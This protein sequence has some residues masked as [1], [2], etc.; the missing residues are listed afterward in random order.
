MNKTVLLPKLSVEGIKKN[1]ATY[2]PYILINSF[3]IFVFFI[4]SAISANEFLRNVP[5]AMYVY[6]LLQISLMLLGIILAPI[7]ITSNEF[8]VKQRKK[9]LGLY[10]I[11][12]MEKK[13]IAIIMIVEQCIIY[14]VSI[15]IGIIISV[16]FSKLS[17]MSLLK[18]ASLPSDIKFTVKPV[19]ITATLI[20]FG[21]IAAYNIFTNVY[22]VSRLN[23]I[24]LLGESKKGEK[25][26]RFLAFKA[27]LGVL[28]V[29]SGY[30]IAGIM[31]MDS[32]LFM[33]FFAAVALVVIGTYFLFSSVSIIVLKLLQRNK[34][35]YYKSS[36][37]TTVSG[38][39]YRMKKSART[40]AN[41]CVF[42]TM[43]IITLICT[44][45]LY[46][47]QEDGIRFNYPLDVRYD[48]HAD[49]FD[50]EA[51][52]KIITDTAFEKNV[53]VKEKT[54]FDYIKLRVHKIN[55]HVEFSDNYKELPYDEKAIIRL[56]TVD[57]FNEIENTDLTLGENEILVYSNEKDF[58]QREITLGSYTFTVKEEL[59]KILTESKEESTFANNVYY[60]IFA[61]D[62]YFPALLMESGF[63][64][65]ESKMYTIRF[66]LE[67]EDGNKRE[68]VN[69]LN[70]KAKALAGFD[71][72]KNIFEFGEE[73]RAM[74]GGLLFMGIFFGLI[75]TVCLVIMM[76]YKQITE[77][78]EDKYNFTIMQ[79][80]GMSDDEVRRTI[81]RQILLVFFTP[82]I[83]AVIHTIV[84]MQVV[85][86][87]MAVLFIHS[88]QL[89]ALATVGISLIFTIVYI[90]SYS[91][92]SRAYYRIVK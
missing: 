53:K 28:I 50:K 71:T 20:Y 29:G 44:V 75:F 6:V 21:G 51:F 25:E 19:N 69:I 58:D 76:Y 2:F 32:M 66:N 3:A 49:G 57:S 40:L 92:T 43:V 63:D 47:G 23:P 67:G 74:N 27:L 36:N 82:L 78:Y 39:L 73:T 31:E 18:L 30:Y 35:F 84:G 72:A 46:I 42:S 9:E 60:F 81:I 68:F 83:V 55:E 87:L 88:S 52:D 14:V 54:A 15:I 62:R 1:K 22:N 33:N 59:N 70:E 24:E 11:L 10:S 7:L 90:V 65:V 91:I 45:T 79:K 64:E 86:K 41:I 48:F 12:G 37:F 8:L 38:M 34:K 85:S 56:I 77:G 5:H 16:V 61:D 17:F 89:M 26:P 4:F 13:H 80:V